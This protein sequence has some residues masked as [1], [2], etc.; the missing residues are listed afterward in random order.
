MEYTEDR[1]VQLYFRSIH[2]YSAKNILVTLRCSQGEINNYFLQSYVNLEVRASQHVKK[3][4]LFCLCFTFC[5]QLI[6]SVFV[7]SYVQNSPRTDTLPIGSTS[8]PVPSIDN[9]NHPFSSS[10]IAGDNRKTRG[11]GTFLPK[12]VSLEI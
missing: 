12:T 2:S 8:Y 1:S 3:R 7:C 11:T 10:Y 6:H 5:F 9:E 4:S